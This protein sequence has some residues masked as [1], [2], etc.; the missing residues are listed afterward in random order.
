MHDLKFIRDHPEK[1]DAGL[2]VRG[3]APLSGSILQLDAQRRACVTQL[4]EWQ[5][6]RNDASKQ[7]GVAKAKGDATAADGLMAGVADLKQ[8]IQDGEKQEL[9]VSAKLEAALAAIPNLPLVDVPQGADENSNRE[10]RR[11]GAPPE[12]S[13]TP[14]EHVD[15][16]E[17]LG[18]MDFES[19]AKL[20]GA[21]FVV[22]KGALAKLERALAAF[23]LDLHTSEFGYTEV[24]PPLMVR[25]DAMFGT[26]QLPKFADD[27]FRAGENMW[28][29]PTA[30]VP[31]T[32]LVRESILSEAELPLRVTAFT[33]CFRAEAGAA[34]RDTR[35]M[36][37]LHQFSKVELVSIVTPENS[38]AEHER[39]T[40]CAEEVL[41]R[42]GLHYRVML[43]CTGDMGF[44]SRKTYD[45]EVWLPGQ[46]AFRE[47]SSCSQCG[48]FQ[49]R[50]MQ[51]RYRAKDDKNVQFVHT[52][53]GSG[54]AVGRTM[55]AILENYQMADGLVMV[56]EALRPYMGGLEV[57]G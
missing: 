20:S 13:F 53:N 40:A 14:K 54:L 39:M 51:A 1:F 16:G 57:I 42:L 17:R 48:D 36:I 5:K 52:L 30:E 56:P 21:R 25:D 31:L 6:A 33:P 46:N 9:A 10:I 26:A 43:L 50:R 32:N 18:L 45:L 24:S 55:V 22:L 11:H 41:K 47:I 35:G 44:A 38:D 27:Q 37:R 29:I 49:A 3:L 28:L 2:H 7:I 4:Q 34:G 15:L 23:M 19:A 8:K 12:F